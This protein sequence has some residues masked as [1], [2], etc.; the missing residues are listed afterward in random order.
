MIAVILHTK[1]ME[2][3]GIVVSTPDKWGLIQNTLHPFDWTGWDCT[4]EVDGTMYEGFGWAVGYNRANKVLQER[5]AKLA[6]IVVEPN[7]CTLR[8]VEEVKLNSWRK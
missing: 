4:F 8:P 5:D 3:F 7:G 2:S 6:S 1:G